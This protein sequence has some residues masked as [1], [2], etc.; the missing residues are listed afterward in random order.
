MEWAYKK[1]KGRYSLMAFLFTSNALTTRVWESIDRV[2]DSDSDS[3]AFPIP[4]YFTLKTPQNPDS[5][6]FCRNKFSNP[7][8][9]SKIGSRIWESGVRHFLPTPDSLPPKIHRLPTPKPCWQ[10]FNYSRYQF[11]TFSKHAQSDFLF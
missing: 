11:K 2:Y 5:W 4:D 7:K 1:K 10:L 9:I 3:L 6:L 8:K